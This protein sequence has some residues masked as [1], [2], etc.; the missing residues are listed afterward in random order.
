M[1]F[2]IIN[3]KIS[4][5][6]I[7]LTYNSGIALVTWFMLHFDRNTDYV[8]WIFM[9]ILQ[10]CKFW[11]DI[12]LPR[13]K[14]SWI[15]NHW[16]VISVSLF[17]NKTLYRL[18]G[19]CFW[20]ENHV[21]VAMGA[22]SGCYELQWRHMTVMAS[23]I[24]CY[25]IICLAFCSGQHKNHFYYQQQQNT[26]APQYWLFVMVTGGNPSPQWASYHWDT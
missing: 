9:N 1:I 3:L 24:T 23:H 13:Q 10:F 21:C 7:V 12:I 14:R 22:S 8:M 11:L 2:F 4:L 18:Y 26:K 20:S 25:S 15:V 19:L 5:F 16:Y 17:C 6:Q